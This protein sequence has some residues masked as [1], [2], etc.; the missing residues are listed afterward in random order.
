MATGYTMIES[1]EDGWWYAASLP[2]AGTVA[3]L[4]TD[5][6]L[7]AEGSRAS[8]H[9]WQDQLDTTTYTKSFV[10]S[11]IPVTGFRIVA[12]NSSRLDCNANKN[13][14][15][16]GDAAAAFDPLSSQGVFNA[17]E[18]GLRAAQA[19]HDNFTG[20]SESLEKCDRAVREDFRRYIRSRERYYSKEKRWP[21]SVFWHRRHLAV[22]NTEAE[23]GP[24]Q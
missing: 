4:M 6:D 1:I 9:Y 24:S 17:L 11:S 20:Q 22:P 15:A 3:V 21:R 19:I 2:D 23:K 14:L 18:S 13:W 5:A 10:E 8:A 12:A 16:V 7:Y